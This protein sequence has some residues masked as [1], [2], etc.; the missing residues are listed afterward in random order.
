[1]NSISLKDIAKALNVSKATVSYVLNGKGDEKRVSKETQ[2]KIID[3]AQKHNYKANLLARSL[4]MGKSNMIGIVVPNIADTFFARIARRIEIQAAQSGYDVI[5]SSTG[6]NIQREQKIIQSMLDRK[7]D[8]LIIASCQKN[9]EDIVRLV[10]NNFPFVLIDRYYPDI[11]TN[12]V[13]LDNDAGI[14]SAV[15][16]L[17]KHGKKRIGF[18]SL[19]MNI[20]T[21]VE[22]K[23]SYRATMKKNQ[24]KV[25]DG[26]IAELNYEHKKYDLK[27]ILKTMLEKPINAASIVF[28]TH[29]LAAE[30]IRVLKCMGVKV[31]DDL[32]IVSYGQKADFDIMETPV[33]SVRFPIDEIGDNAVDILL[34]NIEEPILPITEKKLNTELII[35]K[36]CGVA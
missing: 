13:G 14:S 27:K 35:R 4:S 19:D 26:F 34:R 21:L 23:E 22:R 16:H 20:T 3:F 6:E 18:V 17:I 31:P 1:M 29:F 8:G 30:S 11:K 10:N 25:E 12:Y 24:L 36:S 28:A 9:Q 32:A 5:F 7:V 33:T 2:K 15:S